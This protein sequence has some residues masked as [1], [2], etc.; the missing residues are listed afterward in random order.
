MADKDKT[1]LL[2]SAVTR[3][4]VSEV[5]VALGQFRGYYAFEAA[6]QAAKV[7][8][9]SGKWDNLAYL[10][11]FLADISHHP[12]DGNVAYYRINKTT[13]RNKS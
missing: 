5:E 4:N 8:I 10:A 1:F 3:G 6:R 11:D 12:P 2:N 9:E 7:A 13:N